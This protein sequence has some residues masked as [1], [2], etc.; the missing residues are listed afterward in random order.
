MSDRFDLEQ[1]ILEC[2]KVTTDI[3]TVLDHGQPDL[4]N[5][6]KALAKMSDLQFEKLWA[7]FETMCET[8]QFARASD[9]DSSV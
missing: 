6:L 3:Q 5:N 2:W 1:Q 4:E 9:T 8:R 7:I